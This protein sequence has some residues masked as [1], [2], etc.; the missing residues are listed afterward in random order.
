MS[1]AVIQSPATR[2]RLFL[3]IAVDDV[4][5]A[6]IESILPDMPDIIPRANWHLTL[7]FLGAT[8]PAVIA[9]L[10]VLLKQQHLSSGVWQTAYLGNL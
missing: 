8:D 6:R 7:R 5:A 1:I 3:G 2:P 10:D 9:R 4:C